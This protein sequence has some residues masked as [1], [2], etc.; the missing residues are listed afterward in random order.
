MLIGRVVTRIAEGGH[1]VDVDKLLDRFPRTQKAIAAA[2]S[3]ADALHRQQPHRPPSLHRVPHPDRQA[4]S[5][6][7]AQWRTWSDSQRNRR[8]AERGQPAA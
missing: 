6:R 3:V 1:A 4:R 7:H 5:I 2:S 8:V